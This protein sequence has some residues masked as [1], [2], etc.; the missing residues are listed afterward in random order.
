MLT[1]KYRHHRHDEE[2][3]SYCTQD[4]KYDD[5]TG[6]YHEN[7]LNYLIPETIYITRT[8]EEDYRRIRILLIILTNKLS[9][10]FKSVSILN[11]WL[12]HTNRLDKLV[13][14]HPFD[15][16]FFIAGKV[17]VR[18]DECIEVSK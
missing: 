9:S 11:T 1:E 15:V 8:E 5:V 7:P 6:E 4:E 2:E 18:D 14:C 10:I 12:I 17:Y 13:C 3:P 16:F